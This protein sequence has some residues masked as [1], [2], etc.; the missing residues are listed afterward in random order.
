M[1]RIKADKEALTKLKTVNPGADYVIDN[2]G[3][4]CK[5]DDFKAQLRNEPSQR[6]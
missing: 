5:D 3:D 1:S 4:V 6:G 2:A